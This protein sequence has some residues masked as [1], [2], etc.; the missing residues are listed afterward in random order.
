MKTTL[1]LLLAVLNAAAGAAA[2]AAVDACRT[3]RALEK[4]VR[5][6]ILPTNG[7]APIELLLRYTGCFTAD[8]EPLFGDPVPPTAVR[9]YRA[10]GIAWAVELSTEDG[11]D[12]TEFYIYYVRPGDTKAYPVAYLKGAKTADIAGGRMDW[13]TNHFMN[14]SPP[15]FNFQARVVTQ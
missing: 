15:E 1:A 3:G 4:P 13:G 2:P 8:F 5:L 10:D 14:F 11:A 9:R 12:M 6:S 7:S